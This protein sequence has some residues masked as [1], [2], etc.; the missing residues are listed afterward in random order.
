MVE[1]AAATAVE[2]VMGLS[3]VFL[4]FLV[5]LPFGYSVLGDAAFVP[6]VITVPLALLVVVGLFLVLFRPGV[7]V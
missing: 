4:T 5:A 2:K 6:T 3:G 7:V 1:P